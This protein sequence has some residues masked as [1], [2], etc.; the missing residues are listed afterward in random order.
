MLR[1]KLLSAYAKIPTVGHPGEDLGYDLYADLS[2][3]GD[4]EAST[5]SFAPINIAP[6]TVVAVPTGI[7]IEFKPKA[8][9]LILTRSSMAKRGLIVVGG[10]ID[11]GYRGKVQVMLANLTDNSAFIH[12]SDKIAQLV[13]FPFMA[14]EAQPVADL[15]VTARMGG[16]FGSTGK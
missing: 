4:E 6:H 13:Q 8:G 7:S 2:F 10:V 12:H 5:S 3:I 11:A 1:V 15:S 9:G 16:G 14:M